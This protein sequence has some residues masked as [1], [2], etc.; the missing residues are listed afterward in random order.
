MSDKPFSVVVGNPPYQGGKVQN[1]L[2]IGSSPI[3]IF[4]HFQKIYSKLSDSTSLI[5][6]G[7]R[8]ASRTGRGMDE[9]GHWLSNSRALL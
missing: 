5:Y 8:W 7:G 3:N 2:L 6:P 4:H 9:F 1:P